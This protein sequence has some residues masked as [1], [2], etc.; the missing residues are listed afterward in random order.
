MFGTV[1]QK[2][3]AARGMNQS[4]IFEHAMTA[5]GDLYWTGV[6]AYVH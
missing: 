5:K 3:H 6:A 2:N 1:S 4:Q